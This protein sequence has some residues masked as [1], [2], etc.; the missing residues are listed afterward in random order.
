VSREHLTLGHLLSIAR[1][2]PADSPVGL[3]SRER[4][5]GISDAFTKGNIATALLYGDVE[6][7]CNSLLS[8]LLNSATLRSLRC[9]EK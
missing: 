7:Q 6:E 8:D 3:P 4:I 5:V 1:C 9:K 2:G